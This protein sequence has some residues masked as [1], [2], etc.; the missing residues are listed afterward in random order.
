MNQQPRS[1]LP[2]RSQGG[3]LLAGASAVVL[4][5]LLGADRPT[6]A[7]RKL[8]EPIATGQFVFSAGHSCHWFV[9]ELLR[10]MAR[11]AG[12]QGHVHH[13]QAIGYSRV[14]TQ[15]DWPEEKNKAKQALRAGKVDTLTL[16]PIYL[17][18]EGIDK[19]VGLALEHNP[20]V[21]I[22]LQEGWLPFDLY[23]PTFKI[24]LKTV[25]RDA[26]TGTELRQRH[27][28]Y[29][30]AMQ[31]QV[32]ELNKKR[33]KQVLFIVP[34]GHAVIALREKIRTGKAPGLKSQGDLFHDALG[35]PRPPLAALVTYCH[36][37]A[38]YRQSPVGLP[39]PSVLKT[40]DEPNGN[41]AMN[42][43]LQETAWQAVIDHP[44]SGLVAADKP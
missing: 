35:H 10:P 29:F 8:A 16:A 37:A 31:E 44:L 23:D 4:V 32:R 6:V 22:T 33:G 38:I 14:I 34:A 41:E 40:D 5:A 36:F 28:P 18:D 17:P 43:L 21:R 39:V 3:R 27:A 13:G 9:P 2:R 42:R 19:F 15:W 7:D 25:D 26:L 30:K 12:I 11:A 1:T 24:R 20:R